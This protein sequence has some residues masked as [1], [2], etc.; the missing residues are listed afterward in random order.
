MQAIATAF[1]RSKLDGIFHNSRIYVNHSTVKLAASNRFFPRPFHISQSRCYTMWACFIYIRSYNY[2]K[3]PTHQTRTNWNSSMTANRGSRRCVCYFTHR[4]SQWQKYEP[5]GKRPLILRCTTADNWQI[6]CKLSRTASTY[7]DAGFCANDDVLQDSI[8][9]DMA[10]SEPL[11][12]QVP[13]TEAGT[14]KTLPPPGT[15]SESVWSQGRYADK[16]VGAWRWPFTSTD[17]RVKNACR[18]IIV[19]KEFCGLWNPDWMIGPPYNLPLGRRTRREVVTPVFDSFGTHWPPASCL[20]VYT[21]IF[22]FM[23]ALG[24]YLA[25]PNDSSFHALFILADQHESILSSWF[26]DRTKSCVRSTLWAVRTRMY[27]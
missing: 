26:W 17:S 25:V 10:N 2:F 11:V 9:C 4:L 3:R 15:T 20:P 13:I 24:H 8:T 7:S 16:A 23:F 5:Q 19:R 14:M 18:N 21:R 6:N 27:F 12:S 22:P 1:R